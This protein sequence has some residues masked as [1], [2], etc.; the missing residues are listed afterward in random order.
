[1]IHPPAHYP[2]LVREI[3]HDLRLPYP[4]RIVALWLAMRTEDQPI[5]RAELARS[6]WMARSTAQD[7]LVRL[8]ANGYAVQV[9][10]YYQASD[11]LRRRA[12]AEAAEVTQ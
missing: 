9:G 6:L 2:S 11:G 10:G 1:V 7:A 4:A 3:T 8:V 12:K 5:T